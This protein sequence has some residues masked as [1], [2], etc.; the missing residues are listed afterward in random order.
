MEHAVGLLP[1][2]RVSIA[3]MTRDVLD[4]VI[5]LTRGAAEDL[6]ET[7][8]LDVVLVG[9]GVLLSDDGAG[10]FLVFLAG[11]DGLVLQG[12]EGGGVVG[13]GAVVAV[14]VH[15]A[16]AVPGAE[17]LEGAVDGNLLG[18]SAQTVTVGVWVG[19]EAGLEDGVGGGLDA[20]DHVGGGE[21]GL[22]D[23]CEVVF[24]VLVQGESAE[25]TEGHFGL[26]PDLGQVEDAPA[27]FLG[28]FGAEDLHVA[29]PRGVLSPLDGSKQVLCVPVWV[30]CGK[31]AGLLISE[32]LAALIGLAVD[33]NVVERAIRLNPFVGVAGV[34]VH[35]AVG[36][37][38][39]TVTE[40]MHEL[41]NRFLVSGEVVPEHGGILQVGL[42]VALLGVD[43]DGEFGRIPDE[44]NRG[45]VEDPVPV[46]LLCVELEGKPTGVTSTVWRTL[47]TT[48]GRETSEHLG[49]LANALEHVDDSLSNTPMSALIQ[50][51]RYLFWVDH[52]RS[53]MSSVTSNSP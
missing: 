44:E 5:L 31:L 10:P 2:A 26:R 43:E 6:P 33:L 25:T 35:V 38:S 36:V 51:N 45:V 21:G 48:N 30:A 40:E 53:L 12:A 47:L 19:E 42:G 32:G 16:V 1:H 52:T 9:D 22:F 15:D 50:G 17:G 24:G 41:V 34:A 27:E 39:A 4:K 8:G 3:Q 11:L 23:L 29:G 46:A 28:L 7:V 13:V 20:G 14:D 49:L 37:R 18:V